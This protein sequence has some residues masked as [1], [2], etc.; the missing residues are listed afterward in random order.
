MTKAHA[1][2]GLP[3]L[4]HQFFLS[5]SFLRLFSAEHGNNLF[6]AQ[7]LAQVLLSLKPTTKVSSSIHGPPKS[8][9]GGL[10]QL[11]L[12]YLVHK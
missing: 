9:V 8:S 6:S 4:L 7:D 10:K 5:Q 3:L 12:H 1:P 2:V 11:P